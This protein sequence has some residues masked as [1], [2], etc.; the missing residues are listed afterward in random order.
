MNRFIFLALLPLPFLAGYFL[1]KPQNAPSRTAPV[2][3]VEIPSVSNKKSK[4]E[5]DIKT[6]NPQQEEL[7]QRIEAQIEKSKERIANRPLSHE[8]MTSMVLKSQKKK[9]D[10]YFQVAG[11]PEEDAKALL[12]VRFEF[13]IARRRLMDEMSVTKTD[14]LGPVLEGRKRNARDYQTKVIQILG[15]NRAED[16]LAFEVTMFKDKEV[17]MRKQKPLDE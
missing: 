11:I 13:E 14:D 15:R 10:A 9:Y 17:E 2:K 8:Q 12:D 4:P 6:P 5:A 16:F 7:Q 3:Q 1:L